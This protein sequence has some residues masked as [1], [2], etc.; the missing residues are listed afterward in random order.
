[1]LYLDTATQQNELAYIYSDIG[2]VYSP[3]YTRPG[4]TSDLTI[5]LSWFV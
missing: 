3:L 4:D 2:E 1:M 5:A